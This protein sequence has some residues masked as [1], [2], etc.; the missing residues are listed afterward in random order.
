MLG[1]VKMLGRMTIPG[2]I[3]AADVPAS[4]A[5]PQMDPSVAEL[6]AFLAAVS[7]GLVCLDGVQMVAFLRHGILRVGF[8]VGKFTLLNGWPV[9]W[10][11]SSQG[12]SPT[13]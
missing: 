11:R 2:V 12:E 3:A 6:K 1:R 10:H 9:R 8:Q 7:I 4:S 13:R 5:E